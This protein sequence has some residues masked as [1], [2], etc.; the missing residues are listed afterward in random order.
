MTLFLHNPASQAH[1]EELK[2][3][4][5]AQVR[6]GPY[7]AWDARQDGSLA[8]RLVEVVRAMDRGAIT[9]GQALEI[10]SRHRI[11]GFHFGR[12]LVD[13]VDEGVYREAVYD[14]VA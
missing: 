14:E 5:L 8:E 11:P 2:D 13:M 7:D 6:L 4:L 9:S 12:W 10:F 1:L 3:R